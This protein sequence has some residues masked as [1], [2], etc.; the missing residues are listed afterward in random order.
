MNK[1]QGSDSGIFFL[2]LELILGLLSIVGDELDC[3]KWGDSINFQQ[4]HKTLFLC[5]LFG[6]RA[7]HGY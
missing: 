2:L 5:F 6:R 4:N 7:F 1:K 3:L